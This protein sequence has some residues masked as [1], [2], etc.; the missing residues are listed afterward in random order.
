MGN[1]LEI[2]V[3][4]RKRAEGIIVARCSLRGVENM[5]LICSSSLFTSTCGGNSGITTIGGGKIGDSA[6]SLSS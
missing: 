6:M 1:V 3:E 5:I 4:D 2:R